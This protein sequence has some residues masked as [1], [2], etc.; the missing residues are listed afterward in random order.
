M[1]AHSLRW[2]L[3]KNKNKSNKV[4]SVGESAE[5]L[6]YWSDVDKNVKWKSHYGE[7]HGSCSKN[8]KENCHIIQQFYFRMCIQN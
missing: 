6:E 1:L 5:K 2:L 4:T 3:S 7:Q 8:E